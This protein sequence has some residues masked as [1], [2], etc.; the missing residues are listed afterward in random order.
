MQAVEAH[1]DD[2]S[3]FVE[4]LDLDIGIGLQLRQEVDRGQFEKID[5]AR[6]QGSKCGLAVGD[7]L[8]DHP[9]ELH[10]LA[11]RKTGCG[12]AARDVFRPF[13]ED[14]AIARL[15]RLFVEGERARAQMLFHLLV[16]IGLGVLLAHDEAV[17]SGGGGKRIDYQPER[18]LQRQHEGLI[19]LGREVL[20]ALHHHLAAA[21]AHRP[22]PNRG[23]TIRR[24]DRRSVLPAEPVTQ[25]EGVGAAV[26]AHVPLSHHLRLR[27]EV[28]VDPE[29][30]VVHHRAVVGGDGRRG[31][32]RI[33]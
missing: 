7:V 27:A 4:N 9:I 24:R 13:V 17:G 23:D 5:L 29:Q 18:L 31:P 28:R 25:P 20:G 12:L 22:A 19:V 32:N 10:H 15:R 6:F 33:E 21:V 2:L 14:V 26:R 30:H 11:A 1:E 3:Q 8:P 16:G